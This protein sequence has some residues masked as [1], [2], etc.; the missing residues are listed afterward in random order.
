MLLRTEVITGIEVKQRILAIVLLL[1]VSS[2]EAGDIV[3]LVCAFQYGEIEIKV[4]YKDQ[5]VNDVPALIDDKE[6]VWS[7]K[8]TKSLAVINRYTGVM[9]M[10]QGRREY[11]GM[12][13]KITKSAGQ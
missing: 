7:N 9:Q 12:C 6:I 1:A 10:S 4:N 2:A 13:N 5:T 3:R 11:T 8:K